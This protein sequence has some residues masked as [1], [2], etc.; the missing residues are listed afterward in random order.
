MAQ[1]CAADLGAHLQF[2]RMLWALDKPELA[3]EQLLAASQLESST[4]EPVEIRLFR[5]FYLSSKA[6]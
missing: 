5:G 2:G 4:L 1:D 6:I 3:L